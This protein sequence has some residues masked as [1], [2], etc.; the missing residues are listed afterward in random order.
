MLKRYP[1]LLKV[2]FALL[3]SFLA[4]F[5]S[6]DAL[7]IVFAFLGVIIFALS[8]QRF[9]KLF[10]VLVTI[11]VFLPILFLVSLNAIHTF[12]YINP[13]YNPSFHSLMFERFFGGYHDLFSGKENDNPKKLYPD[14]NLKAASD[15]RLYV[16]GLELDFS[17]DSTLISIPSNLI[18]T[19]KHNVLEISAPQGKRYN[20]YTYVVKIGT[21]NKYNS[22]LVHSNGTALKGNMSEKVNDMTIE[23]NGLALN[24]FFKVGKMIIHCNGVILSG[25]INASTVRIDANGLVAHLSLNGVQN[26]AVNCNSAIGSV[27]YLDE[28]SG[29]RLFSLKG[30]AGTFSVK[31]PQNAGRLETAPTGVLVKIVRY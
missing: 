15:V 2:S 31:I 6:Q 5:V 17:P 23:C 3:L 12:D 29:T 13:F 10:I 9:R 1:I 4:F 21:K 18:T 28:W 8:F 11:F 16:S 24:G 30:N 20:N 7:K 27:S 19:R 26:F 25:E 22:L 14:K